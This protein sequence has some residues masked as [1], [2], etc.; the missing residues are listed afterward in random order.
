MAVT[1]RKPGRPSLSES[2][3]QEI[4]DNI[5]EIARDLFVNEGYENTSM[6]KIAAQAG[7]APT[8]IYYYFENKKAIL[9]HF[10][11]DISEDLW[12]YCQPPEEILGGDPLEV[13]RYL[14]NRNVRYWLNN[15]K[16]YQLGIATQDF[17]AENSEN[18]NV[19]TAP[20]TRQYIEVMHEAVQRCIDNGTF[21][22]KDMLMASQVIGVSVYGIY[23]AFYSLP[24][25][26]WQD[27]EQLIN[28]AIENTLLGLRA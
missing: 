9:R 11:N 16:S 7:F 15:P 23:G 26:E 22:I 19:Y 24:T 1:K 28:N 21:R 27:R 2:Q 8:K 20:G 4:R 14:M 10:W 5:I 13:I 6:R 3:K 17:K 18:F 12:A 25:V